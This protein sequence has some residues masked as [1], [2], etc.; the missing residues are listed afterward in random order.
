M[1]PTLSNFAAGVRQHTD[2]QKV[3]VDAIKS[4]QCDDEMR[5]DD[6]KGQIRQD[7][8][9][10]LLFQPGLIKNVI[11]MRKFATFLTDHGVPF[12]PHTSNYTLNS[13]AVTIFSDPAQKQAPNAIQSFPTEILTQFHHNTQFEG[14]ALYSEPTT[15]SVFDKAAHHMAIRFKDEN[16]KFSGALGESWGEFISEYLY[17]ADD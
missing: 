5:G 12:E 1:P 17:A 8:P 14:S 7:Y 2:A 4:Y 3:F 9:P 10:F 16:K 6:L 11:L 15:H 13:I